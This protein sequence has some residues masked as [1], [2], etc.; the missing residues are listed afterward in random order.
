MIKPNP[1]FLVDWSHPQAAGLRSFHPFSEGGGPPLDLASG[2]F[3]ATTGSPTWVAGPG[4]LG[5]SGYASGAYDAVDP[6]VQFV[7]VDYPWWIAVG[8]RNTSTA[9]QPLF[10]L[11]GSGSTLISAVLNHASTNRVI[12][13]VCS[14]DA[15][16]FPSFTASAV[17]DGAPHVYQLAA[18]S[19]SSYVVY[20]DGAAVASTA[21]PTGSYNAPWY[22]FGRSRASNVYVGA[23]TLA[24]GS[25]LW[26]QAGAGAVPDPGWL[27]RDP[28]AVLSPPSNRTALFFG[29]S[30][31][32]AEVSPSSLSS[33][34]QVG[35]A[36]A[37]AGTA[38]SADPL[39]SSGL[40]AEVSVGIGVGSSADPLA[41]SGSLASAAVDAGGSIA[42]AAAAADASGQLAAPFLSL[43][44]LCA[45]SSLSSVGSL[46]TA[47]V[48]AEIGPEH[49]SAAADPLASSSL[50]AAVSVEAGGSIVVAGQPLA[51]SGSLATASGSA[52][53]VSIAGPLDAAG[54]VAA[55][56][57]VSHDWSVSASVLAAAGAVGFP[58]AQPGWLRRDAD[59]LAAMA[60]ALDST[61]EFDSVHVHGVLESGRDAASASRAAFVEPLVESE[62]DLWGDP[63]GPVEVVSVQCVVTIVVRDQDPARRDRT[64][65]RLKSVARNALAGR[66]L[67]NLT[68]PAFTRF[69]SFQTQKASPPSRAVRGIFSYKYL[70]PSYTS[71]S[72]NE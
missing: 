2:R 26:H 42:V 12:T 49:V 46:A 14:D 17:T 59:V 7:G 9:R 57:S 8:F 4:G 29:A 53:T 24:D 31:T 10:V 30:S 67:C 18:Y 52:S 70:V 3:A 35:A 47:S 61:G 50:I 6:P 40:I 48:V 63:S 60:A 21:A 19:P 72:V 45:P 41:S 33:V 5:R 71:Y 20:L 27:A 64:A 1:G 28:F 36:T 51:S 13:Y 62:A 66:S 39:A 25:L 15:N 43:D 38:A 69:S 34:G 22:T 44:W 56:V 58:D 16:K 68:M 54:S 32:A 11:G 37:E 65:D 55:A 23:A